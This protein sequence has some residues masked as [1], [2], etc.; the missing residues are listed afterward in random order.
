[1]KEEYD[2]NAGGA[3]RNYYDIDHSQNSTEPMSEPEFNFT[4]TE[5][6]FSFTSTDVNLKYK[7]F[8][9]FIG[10]FLIYKFLWKKI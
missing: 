1:M 8:F 4:S 2:D 3:V 5:P 9:P 7:K 6:E 10:A